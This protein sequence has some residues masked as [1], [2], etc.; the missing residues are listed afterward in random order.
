MAIEK[1]KELRLNTRASKEEVKR[2]DIA[3]QRLGI[4][5]AVIIRRAVNRTVDRIFKQLEG[6]IEPVDV[7]I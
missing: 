5:K 6:G 2:L 3:A 1:E 7:Q 4:S